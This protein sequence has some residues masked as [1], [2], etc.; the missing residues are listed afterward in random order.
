MSFVYFASILGQTLSQ[1][2]QYWLG[3]GPGD[4]DP[5]TPGGQHGGVSGSSARVSGVATHVRRNYGSR[6][7][8]VA[9]AGAGAGE[10]ERSE[11]PQQSQSAASFVCVYVCV[12]CLL[13]TSD[14]AD[15]C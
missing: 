10:R 1:D 14:A 7:S 9:I 15:D 12:C 4:D 2:T 13:Y 11:N 8:T 6:E 5:S 3:V